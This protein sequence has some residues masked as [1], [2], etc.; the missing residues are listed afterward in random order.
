LHGRKPQAR[1]SL[2]PTRDADMAT[3]EL[4]DLYVRK[5]EEFST[6]PIQAFVDDLDSIAAAEG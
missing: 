1:K 5:C 3:S 2:Q 4:K 6:T